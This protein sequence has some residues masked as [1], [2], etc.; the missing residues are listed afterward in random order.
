MLSLVRNDSMVQE[1]S[2]SKKVE[3]FAKHWLEGKYLNSVK[4]TKKSRAILLLFATTKEMPFHESDFCLHLG[5]NW[6]LHMP[7][8]ASTNEISK[9]KKLVDSKVI[10]VEIA[11]ETLN[12]LLV[13]EDEYRLQV[14]R[15]QNHLDDNNSWSILP[16]RPVIEL[17]G[18]SESESRVIVQD[19]FAGV[20]K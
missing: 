19:E 8:Q 9:L 14:E 13:A 12:V 10:R 4:G 17:R 16:M 5:L 11:D 20:F 1:F 7:N 15:G 6:T 3:A 18:G 2:D